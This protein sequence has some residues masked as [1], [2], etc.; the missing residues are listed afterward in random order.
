M[1]VTD[2]IIAAVSPRAICGCGKRSSPRCGP[3]RSGCAG[4]RGAESLTGLVRRRCGDHLPLDGRRDRYRPARA[5]LPGARSG[6]WADRHLQRGAD[7]GRVP[8]RGAAR[9]APPGSGQA[10]AGVVRGGAGDPALG[11]AAH[12]PTCLPRSHSARPPR[13]W[14]RHR[15]AA[16]AC[17]HRRRRRRLGR[18]PRRTP[19]P[20]HCG[21]AAQ[22]AVRGRRRAAGSAGH[23]RHCSSTTVLLVLDALRSRGRPR[24]G[25]P[26]VVTA[27]VPGITLYTALLRG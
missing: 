27:F 20:R 1:Q 5:P 15:A 4:S 14:T 23:A 6:H 21:R 12:R 10:P 16:P 13:P 24:A 22:P 2:A 3:R 8:G 17:L 7:R 11:V 18:A 25:R 19:H 9:R 26:A